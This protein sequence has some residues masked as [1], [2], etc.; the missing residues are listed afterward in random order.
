[1]DIDDEIKENNINKVII[2][3]NHNLKTTKKDKKT[4]YSLN[5]STEKK[6]NKEN[7]KLYPFN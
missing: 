7:S 3:K 2:S 5:M 1:M 4:Y 6:S